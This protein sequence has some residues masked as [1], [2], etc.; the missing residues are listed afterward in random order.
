M[1]NLA[2]SDKT[3]SWLIAIAIILLLSHQ[4]GSFIVVT[5]GMVWGVVAVAVVTV[6]ALLSARMA[7]AGG[8]RSLWFLL[9]T[10]LFVLLPVIWKVWR[11]FTDTTSGFERLMELMPFLIGFGAPVM[12]LLLAYAGLHARTRA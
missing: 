2:L 12:L 6:V 1:R 3:L 11:A 7:R 9:P 10:V 5:L 4:I 8:R